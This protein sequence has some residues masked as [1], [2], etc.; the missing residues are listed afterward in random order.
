MKQKKKSKSSKN[1][2][3][4]SVAGECHQRGLYSLKLRRLSEKREIMDFK[5]R[6][7]VSYLAK[8]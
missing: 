5:V 4:S 8:F 7:I 2:S 3:L 6:H 1:L